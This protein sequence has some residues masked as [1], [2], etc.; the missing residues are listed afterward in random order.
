M[1]DV[2]VDMTIAGARTFTSQPTVPAIYLFIDFP[3][4]VN[5]LESTGKKN[6]IRKKKASKVKMR[7]I[8]STLEVRQILL[9]VL[10][11]DDIDLPLPCHA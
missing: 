1:A 11:T 10:G 5:F 6:A 7:I 4:G 3:R 9:T 2:T 8:S